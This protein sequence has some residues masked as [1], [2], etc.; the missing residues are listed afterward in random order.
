MEAQN[1]NMDIH[2]DATFLNTRTRIRVP[3]DED[4]LPELEEVH[5]RRVLEGYINLHDPAELALSA[6]VFNALHKVTKINNLMYG[7]IELFIRR[8]KKIS[9]LIL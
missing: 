3:L 4:G 6:K 2:A 9:Y 1:L 5:V 7:Y 8:C